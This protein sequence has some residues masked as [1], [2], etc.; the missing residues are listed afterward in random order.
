MLI[1]TKQNDLKKH[2]NPLIDSGQTIGL[3]P[4][5]GAIHQGHLSLMKQALVE[6]DVVVVSI[7]VNPT[8]FNNSEDLKKYPRT[9][10]KDVALI[11][12]LSDNIIIFAPTVDDIYEGN[13]IADGF[14]YDGLE[15][16]MEGINRPGHFNG[17]GTIVK[18]LFEIVTP[19]RA[20][21][22][23]KDFQQLQ[24]IRKM[25]E[26]FKMPVMI[27]GCP[28][29][30]QE[31]GLARS[32]RNELLSAEAKKE[33]ILI[34]QILQ[35]AREMFAENSLEKVNEFVVNEFKKHSNFALEYFE[36]A[37]EET[38]SKATDKKQGIKYR[39]FVVAHID[40][41]RLIDNILLN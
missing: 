39:G 21:F 3:V 14:E 20:Y 19:T 35:Q 1:C 18:K 31:D 25:V 10:E 27:V 32:S 7:F 30:R 33:A 26:K 29:Y 9:L 38:L 28:I 5:M 24:I 41:V 17:V 8:Q 4:T 34:Y 2:L 15:N 11:K 13:T 40:N 16:Q 22:G 36:I 6:N 12:T 23:E 37:D